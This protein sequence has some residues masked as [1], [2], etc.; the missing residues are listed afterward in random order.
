MAV[1]IQQVVELIKFWFCFA[2][3]IIYIYTLNIEYTII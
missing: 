1:C 2:G 3:Q